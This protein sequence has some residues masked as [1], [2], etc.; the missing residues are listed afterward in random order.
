MDV[1]NESVHTSDD[2]DIGDIDAINRDFIVVKRGFIHIH[3]YYI[4]MGEVEGWDGNVVWLE[5]TEDKLKKKYER[6]SGPDPASY[7]IQ[8][9]PYEKAGPYTTS[10]FP[11]MPIIKAKG[12][13]LPSITSTE[14]TKAEALGTE[15][16]RA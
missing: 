9:Y 15:K 1:T 16:K 13:T 5:I 4:P 6:D 2:V 12:R 8:D 10:Y 14:K 11:R 3:Y 7:Y